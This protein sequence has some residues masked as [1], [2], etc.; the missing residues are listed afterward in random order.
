MFVNALF[1]HRFLKIELTHSCY[2]ILAVFHYG[3]ASVMCLDLLS[4]VTLD[5]KVNSCQGM[6]VPNNQFVLPYYLPYGYNQ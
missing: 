6:T 2:Y 4:D 1:H 3:R 5:Q